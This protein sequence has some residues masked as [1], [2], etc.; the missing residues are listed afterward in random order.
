M[1]SLPSAV[2]SALN[3]MPILTIA[4]FLLTTCL[5]LGAIIFNRRSQP[6]PPP[7]KGPFRFL[8]LPPEL[9]LQIYSSILPTK[10]TILPMSHR[11]FKMEAETGYQS[12]RRVLLTN[13]QIFSEVRALLYKSNNVFFRQVRPLVEFAAKN[14][15]LVRKLQ[16]Q[17][18][19]NIYADAVWEHFAV[20]AE[21][22]ARLLS[23]VLIHCTDLQQLS[24]GTISLSHM[25]TPEWDEILGRIM[26]HE[27]GRLR[28]HYTSA[29][30]S[31]SRGA[32]RF[33]EMGTTVEFHA[34]PN[35]AHL[36]QLPGVVVQLIKKAST[37]EDI[38]VGVSY[39][40]R[41]ACEGYEVVGTARLGAYPSE[42][43]GGRTEGALFITAKVY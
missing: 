5:I 31:V 38:K 20:A 26:R 23:L 9:R 30:D 35:A 33:E 18:L 42:Y 39:S 24:L 36:I 6:P 12:S 21:T 14:T 1:I 32:D 37:C 7:P 43:D 4:Q 10:S 28:F 29:Y 27:R 25:Q 22:D 34:S 3:S 15:D 40:F 41:L 16:F 17:P 8:D 19:Y 2:T 13:R 11:E